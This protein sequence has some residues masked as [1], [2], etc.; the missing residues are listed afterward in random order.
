MTS[1]ETVED[2]ANKDI[3]YVTQDTLSLP[4]QQYGKANETIDAKL[5][6]RNIEITLQNYSGD[7]TDWD[8]TISTDTVL[9]RDMF[10]NKLTVSNWY[11]LTTTG[12]RVYANVIKVDA[13]G[14]I[15]AN[16]NNWSNGTNGWNWLPQDWSWW[17]YTPIW[18]I[19]NY[20][21]RGWTPWA[22]GT[23]TSAWTIYWTIAW[24]TGTTAWWVGWQ[25][26]WG[27]G[28]SSGD[29]STTWSIA[30]AWWNNWTSQTHSLCTLWGNSWGTGG[31]RWAWPWAV[32]GTG[33][34][35]T[36][37]KGC[38]CTPFLVSHMI[39]Y[40]WTNISLLRWGC[41]WGSWWG[42]MW[43]IWW[44]GW[45]TQAGWWGWWAGWSGASGWITYIRCKTLVNNWTI[46]ANWWNGGNWWDWGSIGSWFSNGWCWGAWWAWGNW[47]VVVLVTGNSQWDWVVQALGWAWWTAW[48]TYSWYSNASN[49]SN[50]A[51][52]EIF[53]ITL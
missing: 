14:I 46:E 36:Q 16:G 45:S 4:S 29:T 48:A 38:I 22:W 37:Y 39:G 52:W 8:V 1:I 34:S 42:G 7:Y 26:S 2:K 24:V 50:W 43:G 5:W 41:V 15:S 28:T 30:W 35:V 6:I 20:V 13:W 47:W 12:Y 31:Y 51:I 33:W 23:A 18:W 21:G 9:T 25:N 40:D 19:S 53:R 10:Y 27:R 3:E 32:G 11:R 17:S 49:W 44:A